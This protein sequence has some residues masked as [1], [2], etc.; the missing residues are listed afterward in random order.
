MCFQR[1]YIFALCECLFAKNLDIEQC[2]NKTLGTRCSGVQDLTIEIEDYFC[3]RCAHFE[4]EVEDKDEFSEMFNRV[5][6]E[7]EQATRQQRG[8][9]RIPAP[10]LITGIEPLWS[11]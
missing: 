7:K 2:S 1:A 4:D 10:P 11:A 6:C 8:G 5:A 3:E 9:P